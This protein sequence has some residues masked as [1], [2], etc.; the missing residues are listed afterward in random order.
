MENT[1]KHILVPID[2]SEVSLNVLR[3]SVYTAKI[4]GAK[5]TL[6]H[7]I[8]SYASNSSIGKEIG[9]NG[10]HD[11]IKRVVQEKFDEL[12]E[13]YKN[14]G[15]DFDIRITEGKIY[16][17]ITDV[18]EEVKAT[19]ISM[20]TSGATGFE[21]IVGTNALK[22]VKSAKCLVTTIRG[23]D[24]VTKYGYKN[25]LLPLD[26]SKETREKVKLVIETAKQFGS[27]IRIVSVTT[28]K[29]EFIVNK[30]RSQLKQVTGM[31]TDEGINATS[32]LMVGANIAKAVL[33]YAH[34]IEADSIFIMTQQELGWVD[35]I[36]GSA[37][38][39]I[40]NHSE[41]PIISKRPMERKDLTLFP[42]QY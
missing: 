2:F 21:K 9:E 22:V 36:I 40:M 1:N 3:H 10:N 11:E 13:H 38:Q 16:K 26:L 32:K 34:E 7:V 4:I 18:A 6:L 17:Q 28:S 35:Q 14:E 42:T 30:L 19:G 27:K 29:D 39:Q 20:A 23:T 33:E 41:I 5:I 12:V 15:I 24:D 8:E 31:V 37:A 25:I